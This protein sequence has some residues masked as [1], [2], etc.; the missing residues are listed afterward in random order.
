LPPD[1]P[2]L[3]DALAQNSLAMLEVK[4]WDKAEPILRDCIVIREKKAPDDWRTFNAKSMLG[5]ALLGQQ[6]YADAEPLLF[7]GLQGMKQREA[8]IPA[9]A[10]VRLTEALE[11]L[12]QLYDAWGKPD[13]AAEWRKELE[14]EKARQKN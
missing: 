7:G 12:V 10:K 1:S 6:K 11:R 14:A 4:A 8:K 5:Q 2:Q 9:N 13:K 3:G